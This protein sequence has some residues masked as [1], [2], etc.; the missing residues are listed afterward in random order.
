MKKTL[1]LNSVYYFVSCLYFF[2]IL[3]GTANMN[4][5]L[6]FRIPL[7]QSFCRYA[8]LFVLVALFFLKNR[9]L[10]L[11]LL[12]GMMVVLL[13]IGVTYLKIDDASML[14]TMLFVFCAKDI[15]VE[16][17][18]QYLYRTIAL[19]VLLLFILCLIGISP[20]IYVS[21]SGSAR[22]GHS[23]G[24]IGS[25][26]CASTVF[27]GLVYYLYA[28]K[29]RWQ[30]YNFF[31]YSAVAIATYIATR[32]RMAFLLELV[33]ISFFIGMNQK[34]ITNI[35]YHFQKYSYFLCAGFTFGLIRWYG[36]NPSG[37]L[38]NI[39]NVFTTGRLYWCYYFFDS[40]GF[41]VFGQAV[42]LVG[43]K[44]AALTGTNWQNMDNAYAMLAIHYGA[45]VL[46]VLCVAC[47]FLG[48]YLQKKGDFVGAFCVSVLALWGITENSIIV[49]G[50]NIAFYLLG[51]MLWNGAAHRKVNNERKGEESALNEK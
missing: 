51:E 5:F 48:R 16:K 18:S 6:I 4:H 42:N 27:T 2:S 45:V 30:K 21:R 50:Y 19:I 38:Q 7:F 33:L 20:D 22:M 29:N 12:L 24:F 47:F 31:I 36:M 9:V 43:L 3:I 28:N 15:D 25:N 37:T 35:G 14:L 10:S 44:T 32:S 49:I 46:V 8:T 13:V 40:Y 17:L 1:K 34:K 41:S 39:A 11:K 23:F 26:A